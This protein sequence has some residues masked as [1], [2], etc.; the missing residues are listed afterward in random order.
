MK[1]PCA[2]APDSLPE[3]ELY[4]QHG[5]TKSVFYKDKVR[6][7][8][9]HH[10]KNPVQHSI[11]GRNMYLNFSDE[12]LVGQYRCIAENPLNGE[13]SRAKQR[14]RILESH[15]PI[16]AA[17]VEPP[18]R[19][20]V[21]YYAVGENVSL[22][23][24]IGLDSFSANA[25]EWLRTDGRNIFAHPNVRRWL[26]NLHID[27]IGEGDFG[28]Y[29]C[30]YEDME[31]KFI[32][33]RASVPKVLDGGV[34]IIE[35]NEEDDTRLVCLIKASPPAEI[36]WWHN[37]EKVGKLD[38]TFGKGEIKPFPFADRQL[39]RRGTYPPQPEPHRFRCVPM[40]GS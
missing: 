3:A 21:R 9:R 22:E 7:R 14:I 27:R 17:P 11:I 29:A 12:V 32:L 31:Y 19:P 6:L 30:R 15:I 23:C 26:G 35:A 37:A 39:Q 4:F 36:Q 25:I 5:V 18:A 24:P 40:H 16:N 2:T 33:R 10:F 1:L 8:M 13:K 20:E 34:R 38:F 28:A